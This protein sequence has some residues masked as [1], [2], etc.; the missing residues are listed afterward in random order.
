LP[1]DLELP[2]LSRVET[3]A[4]QN[5]RLL[6]DKKVRI[7]FGA[8]AYMSTPLEYVLYISKLG[9]FS[10]LEMLKILTEDTAANDFPEP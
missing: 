1:K 4:K 8:D 3:A 7:A 2:V 5:L 9:V 10:N 6:K